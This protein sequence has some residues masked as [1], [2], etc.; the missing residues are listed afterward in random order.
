MKDSYSV[1]SPKYFD[2]F[3]CVGHKRCLNSCCSNVVFRSEA[4]ELAKL[5]AISS[6]ID[7]RTKLAFFTPQGGKYAIFRLNPVNG[8]C[9]MLDHANQCLVCKDDKEA[10][11]VRCL[12]YPQISTKINDYIERLL[13]PSCPEVVK[14]IYN[15]PLAMEL[16]TNHLSINERDAK[17]V[18][19]LTDCISLARN[20]VFNLIKMPNVPLNKKM[21]ICCFF[22]DGVNDYCLSN[23]FDGVYNTAQEIESMVLSGEFDNIFQSVKFDQ[24]RHVIFLSKILTLR[25]ERPVV[26]NNYDDLLNDVMLAFDLPRHTEFFDEKIFT[27]ISHINDSFSDLDFL[28][29]DNNYFFSN[30]LANHWLSQAETNFESVSLKSSYLNLCLFYLLQRFLLAAIA[31]SYPNDFP[32]KCYSA[33]STMYR[34]WIEES[35][36]LGSAAASLEGSDVS[37][38]TSLLSMM[39]V[40]AK[41]F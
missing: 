9:W 19:E 38:L 12:V 14:L 32:S 33:V 6:E 1:T 37:D 5:S 18:N 17:E 27:S 10:L 23:N 8:N 25:Y 31:S 39:S 13:S 11:P 29:G 15:D 36:M 30:L 21:M 22:V 34:E 24:L 7:V 2:D 35:P 40:P 20:F 26:H 28:L 3:L 41:N 4:H 16:R